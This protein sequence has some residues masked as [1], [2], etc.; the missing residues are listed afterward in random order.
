MCCHSGNSTVLEHQRSQSYSSFWLILV[1]STRPASMGRVSS[2]A[3]IISLQSSYVWS[4]T[5]TPRALHTHR[6][7]IEEM[8]KNRH[9]EATIKC[10]NTIHTH[11]YW[12]ITF[13]TVLANSTGVFFSSSVGVTG[14]RNWRR[15]Q[16][17]KQ[18][19]TRKY[20]LTGGLP[21]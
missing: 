1:N 10:C 17:S 11:T 20:R 14:G 12:A 15:G 2:P 16:R 13:R 5:G 21:K 4:V 3:E 7:S 6:D 8:G 18:G 19:L 9:K